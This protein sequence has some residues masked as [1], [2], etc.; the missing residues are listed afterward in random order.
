MEQNNQNTGGAYIDKKPNAYFI[1]SEGLIGSIPDIEQIVVKNTSNGI[2]VLIRDIATVNIGEAIRYGAL[3]RNGEGEAVG[4]IVMMLKGENSSAVVDRVKE[5]MIQINKSLPEGVTVE[6]FLDRSALVDRAVHTVTKNLIEGAL[7][8]IFVLVLFLG[9]FRAGFVVASVIPLAMLFAISMMNLFGVSGNLMSLGAIDFGLIVDGAV[10]IVEATLH[11]ITN[12]KAGQQVLTQDEMDVKVYEASSRIR[13]SAAFGEIII[14]IVYLPILALVGIEGKMFR[15]MAQTVSFA[16]LGAFI[17]SLTYVPMMSA[18]LLSKK[19]TTKETFSDR[20]MNFF[21]RI[22]TPI[23]NAALKKRLLVVVSAILLLVISIVVFLRMGGEFIPTL[24]EGDFAVETRLLTGSSLSQTID[25]VDQAS[26]LLMKEFPEVKEVIGKIGAAEIPTDPMPMEACDLTILLKDK[27]E[28]VS[29]NNREDLANKMAEKLEA[30]MPGISFGFSQPVQLRMNE[31]IAGVRQDVGIKIFGEDLTQLTALS[32]KIGK[33]VT[34]VPGAKDLYLEKVSGLPQ[35]VININRARVAQYG[36]S[37]ETINQAISAAFAGQS[38]GLVYEGEKRYDLVVRLSEENRQNIDDV[39]NIYITT[40]SGNQ[41]PL[42]QLANIEFEVGPNQVQRED[43]K[44]RIIVGFNVR[45]R[46]IES[47]VRDIEQKIE[48]QV[49]MPPGYYITYGGQFK[50]LEEAKGRLSIAV[51]LALVL[52]LLLL[53]FTFGSLKQSILIFTAIPMSAIG[54]VFALL[55]RGM[56]FSISAGVGFIALFGVAV[57]NGIVLISE[58][59]RLKQGG[60]HNLYEIVLRGTNVRLR[61][62]L[63]TATV[64]SLGFLPMALSNGS[65]AEVQKPLATVVIGGLI[66][67]TILTLVVLPVL[68][69]YFEKIKLKKGKIPPATVILLLLLG[70]PFLGKAQ[71]SQNKKLSVEEAAKIALQNNPGIRS[72]NLQVEQ[73]RQLRKTVVD[74]GKT[75]VQLQYGQANSIKWDNYG[76]ITQAIPNPSLF[77]NGKLLSD[78][79]IKGSELNVRA[80]QSELIYQV[81]TTW[82]QLAFFVELKHLLLSQDTIYGNFLK[83]AAARYKSGETNLLEQKT[84]ETQLIEVRNTLRKNDADI[85]IYQRQLQTLLNATEPVSIDIDSL[86]MITFSPETL[87]KDSLRNPLAAYLRQQIEIADRSIGLEKAKAKPDFTVGYFNQSIIGTQTIN[88][89][90]KYYGSGFRF[91]GFQAGILVPIFYKAYSYR[92]KAAQTE[93]KIVESN[94]DLYS[95]NLKG[96]YEQAVQE[97]M[98]NKTSIDYYE[99]SAK[100]NADLILKQAQTALINGEIGYVEFLQATKTYTDIQTNYLQ[101]INLYNQSIVTIQYLIGK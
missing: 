69:T 28:W 87:Y 52:I 3:T 29:A 80:N 20:M 81:K 67:A 39:R 12:R 11:H 7:I 18:V 42:S 33:I 61:P 26:K 82:Y 17:L 34:T 8:V 99:K 70:S 93:K 36:L 86:S 65:G 66:T 24:E 47:V 21:H 9:N 27:K 63:M 48:Q 73:Q 100:P 101:A 68:Y 76:S 94:Y 10:I 14:L 89:L 84:A 56:P 83:A 23:I 60:L 58:F 95:L 53:F 79:Q 88:G 71:Q 19:I 6:P 78:A 57:L 75:A 16:I 31:L 55:L 97:Y 92:I 35:I 51:P 62:V 98:K 22:Y 45:G 64:A 50:N 96:Q 74:F 40:P 90:E 91:N 4:G 46:D 2:P 15:P 1:R 77:R 49:K 30:A 85:K 59:N 38:A 5:K 72:A 13:N 32:E 43:T 37:V 41:V 25:K 54:G 44:R